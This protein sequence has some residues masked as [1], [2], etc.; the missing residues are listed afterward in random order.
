MRMTVAGADKCCER[1]HKKPAPLP[2]TGIRYSQLNQ[3]LLH[4]V[5]LLQLFY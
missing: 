3:S 5:Y 2:G 4:R 1:E